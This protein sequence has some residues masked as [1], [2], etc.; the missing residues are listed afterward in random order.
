[1]ATFEYISVL[2]SIIVGLG[3]THL[4]VGIARLINHPDRYRV[5]WIHLLWTIQSFEWLVF[6]WWFN[7]TM[8]TREE[9]T[10]LLYTFFVLFV[11][12]SFLRCAVI[13]PID[14]PEDGDF[15]E[16]FFAKR[17]WFF[18]LLIVEGLFNFT[19]SQ[20]KGMDLP[21]WAWILVGIVILVPNAVA[22]GTKNVKFHGALAV[23]SV[24]FMTLWL[25]LGTIGGEAIHAY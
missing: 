23:I 19:D 5:Y 4:L 16:Y 22:M 6:F 8:A 2:I 9:W 17:R 11:V 1:M 18:G 14:F 24:F 20:I 21:V 3:I 25:V 15:R 7:L 12:T 10:G 13:I